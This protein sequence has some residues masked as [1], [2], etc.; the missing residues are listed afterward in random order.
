MSLELW[1]T[2][3][4]VGTFVVIAATAIAAVVQLYHLRTSNQI[5][6]LN[7]FRKA[8][9][10]QEFRG[11]VEFIHMLPRK[12]D[13]RT[14]RAAL[15]GSPLPSELYPLT[16]VGRMYETLGAYVN[17]QMLDADLVC[18]LWAPVVLADWTAMAGTIV[19]M[20][21]TRGPELFENFEYLA[22]LSKRYLDR[23]VSV[24]PKGQPRIAPAD[25]WAAEDAAKPLTPTQ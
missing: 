4:S 14:F 22:L 23:N 24:Y 6:I 25:A 9:E 8:T 13:D 1:S 18:D 7:D 20:R 21:R 10:D 15:M 12:L 16:L 17:R 11:A 19:V 3:A 2:V 5:A